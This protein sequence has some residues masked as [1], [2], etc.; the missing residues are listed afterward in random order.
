M[1]RYSNEL[2]GATR[3]YHREVPLF[4]SAKHTA[5]VNLRAAGPARMLQICMGAQSL[6]GNL[7]LVLLSSVWHGETPSIS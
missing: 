5:A 7:F 1:G 3:H 4:V 6:P 2:K